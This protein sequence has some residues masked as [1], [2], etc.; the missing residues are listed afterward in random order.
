MKTIINKITILSA[1]V[2]LTTGSLHAQVRYGLHAGINLV[3]QAENGTLW[4]NCDVYH[5]Y[6]IG[7]ILEYKTKSI[8]SVQTEL[9]YQKKGSKTETYSE[10]H[11]ITLK[12]EFN[13]L[14]LPLIGRVTIN[15]PGLDKEFNLSF[16][17]GPYMSF[18]TS[19]HSRMNNG[20]ADQPVNISNNTRDFDAGAV[21]G[22]G[23]IYNLS[24][25]KALTAEIRYEMGMKSIVRDK[26]DLR[27]KG[28]GFTLGYRF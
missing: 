19:T 1:V 18:L 14:T 5:G 16:L 10:N 22:G 21:F 13:Y 11:N 9:N 20:S 27:N 28:L 26:P 25:N 17:A 7:G 4:N 8:F 2:I 23:V 3:T 15:D 6:I 12:N 24:G